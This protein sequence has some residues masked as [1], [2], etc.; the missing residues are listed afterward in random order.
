MNQWK[1]RPDQPGFYWL[2]HRQLK[3]P[4]Q[5]L[6][7]PRPRSEAIIAHYL[8]P[9]EIYLADSDLRIALSDFVFAEWY[10]PL[11]PPD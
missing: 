8:A 2:G 4:I 9:D 3:R 1:D 11:Q 10:G 5:S 7:P 6:R